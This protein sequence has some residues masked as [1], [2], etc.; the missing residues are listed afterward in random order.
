MAKLGSEGPQMPTQGRV[1]LRV[2]LKG[3]KPFHCLR[4]KQHLTINTK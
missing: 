2:I 1:E 3:F 4:F